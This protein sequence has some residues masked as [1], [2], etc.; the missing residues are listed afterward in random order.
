MCAIIALGTTG[1]AQP[2]QLS[3]TWRDWRV[4]CQ[5]TAAENT[6]SQRVCKMVQELRQQENGQRVLAISLRR[7]ATNIQAEM[8]LVVPFGLDVRAEI[9]I[10]VGEENVARIPFETCLP[11]GWVAGGTLAEAGLDAMRRG[12]TALVRLPLGGESAMDVPVSLM[13]FTAA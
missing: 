4:I 10:T 11:Q 8:T 5:T 7:S 1:F 13:G 3:E 6:E 2:D 12:E 9:I